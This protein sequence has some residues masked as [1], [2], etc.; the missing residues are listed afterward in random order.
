MKPLWQRAL[1][2]RSK[3]SRVLHRGRQDEVRQIVGDVAASFDL[4]PGD[5]LGR[6]RQP[7]VTLA[8]HVAMYV[9]RKTLPM[10]LPEV[11]AHF[12]RDHTTVLASVRKVEALMLDDGDMRLQ[13]SQLMSRKKETK[14]ETNM[15][16]GKFVGVLIEQGFIQTPKGNP[17]VEW[18]F[19][20]EHSGEA[21]KKIQSAT[22]DRE[23][24]DGE[25]IG[26]GT[27]DFIRDGYFAMG[28]DGISD[29]TTLTVDKLSNRVLLTLAERRF[30]RE[31]G[32]QGSAIEVAF[33]N[34]LTNA[35][36]APLDEKGLKEFTRR[37]QSARV[38]DGYDKNGVAVGA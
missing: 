26:R 5:I 20:L 18:V 35:K 24:D 36:R 28:W 1:A 2:K 11:G 21:I 15:Q 3:V 6:E 22:N 23:A 16:T 7:Y 25:L 13:V 31:N 34:P 30:V 37:I 8:R 12:G 38:P 19:R 27:V 10:S 29:P 33:V 9:V 4:K 32:T 14:E 17:A